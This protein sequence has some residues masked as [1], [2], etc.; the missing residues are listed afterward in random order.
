MPL[1]VCYE[2]EHEV[3]DRARM[4]PRC[5][6][7]RPSRPPQRPLTALQIRDKM[8]AAIATPVSALIAAGIT[9]LVPDSAIP[10]W[11]PSRV[12]LYLGIWFA[13]LLFVAISW[14]LHERF[15]KLALALI[16][17]GVVVWAVPSRTICVDF[18]MMINE[19]SSVFYDPSLPTWSKLFPACVDWEYTKVYVEHP[20][21]ILRYVPYLDD[22]KVQY[23]WFPLIR[24]PA[25]AA[26]VAL[27]FAIV[28]FARQRK[29][30]QRG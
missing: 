3:S 26:F 14:Q 18:V 29:S 25:V 11:I 20:T 9:F 17:S 6:A 7:P 10:E 12:T 19:P 5:G 22:D 13:T 4:C 27:G 2:C 15:G 16:L 21:L 30:I 28:Y 1:I 8:F 23:T 24:L